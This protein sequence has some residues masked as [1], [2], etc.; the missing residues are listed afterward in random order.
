MQGGDDG[1]DEANREGAAKGGEATVQAFRALAQQRKADYEDFIACMRQSTALELRA[2]V[3]RFC[4]A[5]L[6][7]PRYEREDTV[8][9]VYTCT[10]VLIFRR[11]Q[12]LQAAISPTRESAADCRSTHTRTHRT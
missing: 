10:H 5:L 4:K 9:S 2:K 8:V 6:E 7:G 3:Q 11:P 1:V 12:W